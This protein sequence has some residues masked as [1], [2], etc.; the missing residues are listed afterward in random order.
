MM[1]NLGGFDDIFALK[2]F[3]GA[4]G[5]GR[6]SALVRDPALLELV[7]PRLFELVVNFSI[8]RSDV[9]DLGVNFHEIFDVLDG[10]TAL[11]FLLFGR[12]KHV[13]RLL[14]INVCAG[15]DLVVLGAKITMVFSESSVHSVDVTF[16]S[17]DNVV[18]RNL[19]DPKR[20]Q[21]FT[22]SEFHLDFFVIHPVKSQSCSGIDHRGVVPLLNLCVEELRSKIF[23]L[24][25]EDYIRSDYF[26]LQ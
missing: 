22:R 23:Q 2:T 14:R 21:S 24:F 8:W 18:L 13:E 9:E 15:V 26:S 5:V 19:L 11:G 25:L 6:L 7:S 16:I 20:S 12:L 3:P 17:A 4:L 1:G 10:L